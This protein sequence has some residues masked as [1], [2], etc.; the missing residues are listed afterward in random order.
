MYAARRLLSTHTPLQVVSINRDAFTV[1]HAEWKKLQLEIRMHVGQLNDLNCPACVPGERSLHGDGNQKLLTWARDRQASREPYYQDVLFV[2]ADLVDKDMKAVDK[3]LGKEVGGWW[4][5]AACIARVVQHNT[6]TFHWLVLRLD[7][8]FL[9]AHGYS[10]EPSINTLATL[11][12]GSFCACI[13]CDLGLH[14]AASAGLVQHTC[15]YSLRPSIST[16][17]S[18]SLVFGLDAFLLNTHSVLPF[19]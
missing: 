1:A 11:S 16:L 19:C 15:N 4:A 6:P 9:S 3:V 18:L 17:T 10:F 2:S 7:A 13:H 5:L 14:V 12:V 8:L